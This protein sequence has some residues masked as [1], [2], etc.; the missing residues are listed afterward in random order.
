MKVMEESPCPVNVNQPEHSVVI[1]CSM[2][3]SAA[4]PEMIE[5]GRS[6]AVVANSA[7]ASFSRSEDFDDVTKAPTGPL[8][9]L[10]GACKMDGEVVLSE[11]GILSMANPSDEE[12]PQ[13]DMMFQAMRSAIG[14]MAGSEINVSIGY[15][16]GQV[17]PLLSLFKNVVKEVPPRKSSFEFHGRSS[18]TRWRSK[19]RLLEIT[20]GT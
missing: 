15:F 10:L 1:K 14:M 7:E 6:L 9:A 12:P 5:M 8:H 11:G 19:G 4:D 2:P 18:G 20:G 3:A 13:E 16:E 17:K